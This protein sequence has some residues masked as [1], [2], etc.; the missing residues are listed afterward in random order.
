MAI[1]NDHLVDGNKSELHN[2]VT[3]AQVMLCCPSEHPVKTGHKYSTAI[4]TSDTSFCV[5]ACV[6]VVDTEN[7]VMH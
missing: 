6:Y 3:A 1:I 4:M 2:R 7:D 5:C